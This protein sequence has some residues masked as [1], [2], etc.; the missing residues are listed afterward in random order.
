M[1][2]HRPEEEEEEAVLMVVTMETLS[3][4]QSES[5]PCRDPDVRTT[6]L[7]DDD[8]HLVVDLLEAVALNDG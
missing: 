2:L 7:L 8:L 1:R 4:S 3:S 5:V 6:L